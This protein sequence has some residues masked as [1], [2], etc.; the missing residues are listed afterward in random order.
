[1]TKYTVLGTE[2]VVPGVVS[3]RIEF[4][5]PGCGRVLKTTWLF[6]DT[7]M[8]YTTNCCEMLVIFERRE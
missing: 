8:I 6:P 4:I 3:L 5:C 2:D 7:R 1:M